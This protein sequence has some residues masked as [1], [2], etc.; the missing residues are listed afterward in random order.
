MPRWLVLKSSEA[1][2]LGHITILIPE[3]FS[4]VQVHWAQSECFN[5]LFKLGG[6]N[7]EWEKRYQSVR[8]WQSLAEL[9]CSRGLGS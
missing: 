1:A 6:T 5:Q 8:V 7:A 3:D 4:N 9:H 2:I